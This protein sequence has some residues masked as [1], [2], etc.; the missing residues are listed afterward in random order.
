MGERTELAAYIAGH[1]G[2]CNNKALDV[3]RW[4]SRGSTDMHSGRR[5]QE[6]LKREGYDLLAQ[7]LEPAIL[8]KPLH[9][10]FGKPTTNDLNQRMH[11]GTDA[12]LAHAFL[13]LHESI[14]GEH[15]AATDEGT[16]DQ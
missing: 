9:E 14:L 1:I 2:Q 4:F 13:T 8:V 11:V 5:F 7:V 15:T 6:P 3:V 16:K 12:E 10:R